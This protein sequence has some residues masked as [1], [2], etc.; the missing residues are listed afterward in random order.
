M[1]NK[2]IV[3]IH[4][5]NFL[6][7]LGFFNKIYRSDKF[8]LLDN[9]QF[10]KKG[11][12][13]TNR[14]KW[15]IGGKSTW[16]TIP[17]ERNFRGT[18]TINQMLVCETNWRTKLIK[19]LEQNYKK[20]PFYSDVISLIKELLHKETALISEYNIYAIFELCKLL[21]ID[22]K[23]I[24]FSSKLPGFEEK[25]TELLIKLTKAV[26]GNTYMAGG[27]ANGY[28]EDMKFEEE[29][30]R[31]IYQDFKHPIYKQFN[32]KEF[33]QG[34]SIIDALMN[35]GIEHTKQLISKC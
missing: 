8:I 29:G 3:A 26:N 18:R 23:K 33:V 16:V 19:T 1:K 24:I 22:T 12:T 6:P 2:Q 11:G 14:V 17:V 13:W 21:E 31:L 4:Q 32:S 28:Q 25:S 15:I 34:L 20:A 35:C 5:P 10:P 27:G 7:W 9:T 30:I